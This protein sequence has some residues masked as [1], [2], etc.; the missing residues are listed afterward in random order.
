MSVIL[1][2]LRILFLLVHLM[3]PG[4]GT[5]SLADSDANH[6]SFQPEHSKA[7]SHKA[8]APTRG[9]KAAHDVASSWCSAYKGADPRR[10]AALEMREV[11]IVDRFGAWH[12]LV[13]LKAREDFWEDG[14]DMTSREGF[15]PECSVQHVRLI[16]LNTAIAQ[17]AVSYHEGIALRDGDRIPPLSEI[18]TL[19]L[20]R[21]ESTWLI[22][23]QDIVQR[24]VPSE[25]STYTR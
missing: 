18:H 6:R 4:R 1:T 3:S 16:G 15:R 23:A 8:D 25:T 5:S 21:I 12:R 20:V 17:V 10:L 22:S 11:Q 2:F 19:V 13:G 7:L 24:G 9:E 14:L